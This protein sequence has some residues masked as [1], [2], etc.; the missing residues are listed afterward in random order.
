MLSIENELK[1]LNLKSNPES[2]RKYFGKKLNDFKAYLKKE[3]SLIPYGYYTGIGMSLEMC[4][5]VAI[6]ASFGTSN[7][8]IGLVIGMLIGL[9]IGRAKDQEAEKQNRVLKTRIN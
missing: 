3:F 7:I 2:K 1:I 4:F 8:S 6:G 5:G 9:V